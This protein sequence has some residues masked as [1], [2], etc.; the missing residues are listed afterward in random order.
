M[1]GNKLPHIFAVV[2]KHK[3]IIIISI[4]MGLCFASLLYLQVRYMNQVL[5]VR[6]EHFAE[7][8]SQ[9]LN[10]VSRNM[11][12]EQSLKGLQSYM[13]AHYPEAAEVLS[14]DST[15]VHEEYTGAF[16]LTIH[17]QG[18]QN[19]PSLKPMPRPL[20]MPKGFQLR[21]MN[22]SSYAFM[23]PEMRKI[24]RDQFV[25]ERDL[26]DQVAVSVLYTT[27]NEPIE[28]SINYKSLDQT[29]C[30]ELKNH[31]I[32]LEYHFSVKTRSGKLLYQC[33]DYTSKGEEYAFQQIL[34]PHNTPNNTAILT[35]HFPEMKKY[36]YGGL[37]FLIPS[38]IFILVLL[39]TFIFS[40][41]VFLRQKKVSEMK[42]DFVNNMTHELKT[43]VSS[44]SLAVQM[45]LDSSIKKSEQ[46]TKHLSTVISDETK[47]LRMLID[48]V[49]Q[50]SV[51]EQQKI[52]F[53]CK[54]VKA[55]HLVEDVA[56]T[57][58]LKARN[59]GG[60]LVTE[61][62]ATEDEVY[63]DE[64]HFTTVLFNIMDNAYKYRRDDVDFCLKVKTWNEHKELCVS[65]EDNGIGIRKEELKKIFE[66]FYRVHTGNRH[67][68]KGF[69]LGLAYVKDVITQH[70]GQ[71]N[72]ESEVGK[73]TT[74]TIKL[75]LISQ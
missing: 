64:M 46:M 43:P 8:V 41:F 40:L 14:K 29:L 71:I 23:S 9:C 16:P 32:N 62:T 12:M 38:V 27:T 48:V 4:V 73:G 3:T 59:S 51:F 13:K 1:E 37:K 30:S 61:F 65:I 68:V 2:M 36:L 53:N 31:S 44:I 25:H 15:S 47:R 72:A 28:Q 33:P 75:P 24:F 35:V 57:F 45:L 66:K 22:L 60:Q 6:K 19:V 5:R 26:L 67:D 39:V 17:S 49:L 10:F 70:H 69:G 52:R 63:V 34:M 74:F 42:S 18:T 11:E 54:N 58:S 7:A 21:Q 20:K 55:N 56:N 50:T